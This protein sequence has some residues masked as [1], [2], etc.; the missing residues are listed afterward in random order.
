MINYKVSKT[1]HVQFPFLL[2]LT[3]GPD[4]L[5]KKLNIANRGLNLKNN[6]CT[7][8]LWGWGFFHAMTASFSI[9]LVKTCT[10]MP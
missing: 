6:F 5:F 8:C 2:T 9:S 4:I 10:L 7:L 1:R 3:W